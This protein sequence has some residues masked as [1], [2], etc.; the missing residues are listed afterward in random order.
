MNRALSGPTS[1]FPRERHDVRTTSTALAD[2][3]PTDSAYIDSG[4]PD[5]FRPIRVLVVDVEEGTPRPAEVAA[6]Y[7]Q[8]WVLIRSA[9]RPRALLEVD[10]DVELS[11]ARFAHEVER[12]RALDGDR[13]APRVADD[14]LPSVSVVIPTI[15]ERTDEL[16]DCLTAIGKSDHPRFEIVVVDNRRQVPAPDPL[17]AIA[18][19]TPGVRLVRQ[20]RPGISAARNAGVAASTGEIVVFTDDDVRVDPS[21][22]RAIA[23]RFALHPE[24]QAVTGLV[25]PAELETPAQLY[26]E[27]Y[28]GGF[29]A[30]RT[31]A[32][33]S[34]GVDR[35]G[36]AP[37]RR[38]TV[39]ARDDEGA[40]VRRFALYGAGACGAGCN[41]AFRRTALVG[42]GS[43]GSEPFDT[44]LGTG[45]PAKGGEDL[46]AMIDVLWRGGRIGYEPAA[47]VHHVHRRGYAELRRQMGA[48][49]VGFTAMLTAL[50]LREPAHLLALGAHLP[51]AL[52]RLV[53]SS[54]VRLRGRRPG[55]DPA[56]DPGSAERR[57]GGYPPELARDELTGYL[58]GPGNY[59]RSRRPA[60]SAALR[61]GDDT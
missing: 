15:V 58:R 8:A 53:R 17:Q 52:D 33:L 60:R 42:P 38:S 27:R 51:R 57:D 10:L 26:F 24:E 31:F 20:P 7:A 49:G 21:W 12:R 1:P 50:V 2:P 35:P 55:T 11:R 43:S 22:L 59:L 16:A 45:T 61:S 4:T 23:T 47:L 39:V 13:V 40:E 18:D 37:W 6:G 48:Y 56:G 25:L 54:L 44:A 46:A 30:E 3:A 32:P 41:I 29:A 36:S 9:G 28:Y 19:G 14:R 34:Y 5:G